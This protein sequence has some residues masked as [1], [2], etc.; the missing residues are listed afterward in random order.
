MAINAEHMTIY[1]YICA[2]RSS[3]EAFIS[4]DPVKSAVVCLRQQHIGGLF[5]RPGLVGAGWAPRLSLWTPLEKK[6]NDRKG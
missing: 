5:C 6:R 2:S 4:P 3:S 1:K